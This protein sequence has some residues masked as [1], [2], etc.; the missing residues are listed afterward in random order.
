MQTEIMGI[1]LEGQS[2]Q[3]GQTQKCSFHSFF[4]TVGIW[5]GLHGVYAKVGKNR[6]KQTLGSFP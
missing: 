3:A 5:E 6:A 1:G 2:Q 4:E